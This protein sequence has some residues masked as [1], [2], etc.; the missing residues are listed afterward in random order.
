MLGADPVS[1]AGLKPH[2]LSAVSSEEICLGLGREASAKGRLFPS[3]HP[4]NKSNFYFLPMLHSESALVY[5]SSAVINTLTKSNL[6][7]KEGKGRAGKGREGKERE[8]NI[9]VYML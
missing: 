7:R 8:G 6:R 2:C 3:S 1:G 5:S 9:L 4:K